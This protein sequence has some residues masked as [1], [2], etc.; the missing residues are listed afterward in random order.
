MMKIDNRIIIAA[1][2]AIVI[3]IAGAAVILTGDNSKDGGSDDAPGDEST[4]VTD[5]LGRTV[6][7][8]AN[9]DNGIVTIGKLGSVRMLSYFDEG[10]QNLKMVDLVIKT[11]TVN[12]PSGL[13]YAYIDEYRDIISKAQTH[14]TD[15]I[16][17]ADYENIGKLSPSLIIVNDTTYN[18]CKEV[19]DNLAEHFTLVVIDDMGGYDTTPFWTED[20]KLTEEFKA[21]FELMGKVLGDTERADEIISG[22]EK[23]LSEISELRGETADVKGYVTGIPYRGLNDLLSVF[24]NN[25]ALTINGVDS[26]VPAGS[27]NQVINQLASAEELSKYDITDVF[28]DP[29]TYV[30]INTPNSQNALKY[31]HSINGDSDPDNDI[32]VHIILPAVSVGTTWET[33]LLNAYYVSDLAYGHDMTDV[34]LQEK[35][36][37]I[38][39]IFYG[40]KASNALEDMQKFYDSV[41]GGNEYSLLNEVAVSVDNDKF[42][43]V[44]I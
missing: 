41:G 40:D 29:S 7:V 26:A 17:S 39:S 18:S 38:L 28:I 6:E 34:Q 5:F 2:V 42:V 37:S 22:F 23:I 35:Y 31:I 3:V 8:P 20:Y 12:A 21:P 9:L 27:A 4:T 32:R 36:G 14:E 33:T 44:E 1:A 30:K 13:T 43:L 11:E 16:S 19:C 24:P 10:M 15:N 25:I